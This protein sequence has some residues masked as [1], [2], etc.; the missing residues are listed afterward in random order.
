M[1]LMPVW[2]LLIN[3]KHALTPPAVP[4]PPA[5]LLVDKTVPYFYRL[6]GR[7]VM[8]VMNDVDYDVKTE[9][10]YTA[11]AAPSLPLSLSRTLL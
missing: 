3:V 8:I 2:T 6:N 1:L 10:W 4:S 9:I 5:E 11:A 7:C